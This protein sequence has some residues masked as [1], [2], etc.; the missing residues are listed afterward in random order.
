MSEQP[1]KVGLEKETDN[2]VVV[3]PDD[4]QKTKKLQSI[5]DSKDHFKQVKRDENEIKLELKEQWSNY[6]EA[7]RDMRAKAV[8]DYASEMIPLIEAGLESG[9]LSKDDLVASLGPKKYD[10]DVRHIA[11]QGG[12]IHIDGEM[13]PLPSPNCDEIYRQ[14]ER[15]ER[16]LGLG[17]ELEENKGPAEI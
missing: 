14:L 5:Q 13:K 12:R 11:E 4:Y 8:A 10:M 17:L 1:E 15:I 3:D 9:S 6:R 16:K 2:M 7:Y